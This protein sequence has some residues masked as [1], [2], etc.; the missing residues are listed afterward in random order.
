MYIDWNGH[1]IPCV[2]VPYSPV[3]INDVYAQGKTLTDAWRE[4]FFEH[5]RVWQSEYAEREWKAWQL[6]EFPV[7]YETIMQSFGI[8]SCSMNQTRWIRT[9]KRR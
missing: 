7:Q 2:F 8:G 6:D 9:L 5:I 3:N 4:G 1:V